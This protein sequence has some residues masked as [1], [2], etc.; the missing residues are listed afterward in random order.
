MSTKSGGITLAVAVA[1][2]LALTGCRLVGVQSDTMAVDG[3]KVVAAAGW[4][5][6]A[7]TQSYLVVANVLPGEPMFTRAESDASHPTEG[8]LIIA[9]PGHALGVNVRHVEA[10]IY[11][12]AT[13][14]PLAD[15]HP[16]I[17]IENRT[18]GE[19][20]EVSPTLMQ[21]VNIGALDVHYGNNVS[22]PGDSD[23]RL[24]ISIGDEEAIIDGHLQ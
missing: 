7:T 5:R 17:V 11:D 10:H 20:I 12:R 9:G 13:G 22:V 15:L 3:Q 16:T 18:T 4:T 8:E 24:T 2:A 14:L 6:L 19:R 1:L 23:L 21:D